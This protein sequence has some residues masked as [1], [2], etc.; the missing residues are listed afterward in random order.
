MPDPVAVP[1]TI[2]NCHILTADKSALNAL[3]ETDSLR[4]KL[5]ALN[6]LARSLSLI[7]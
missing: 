7:V 1:E 6:Q 3:E 2:I 5:V 4:L